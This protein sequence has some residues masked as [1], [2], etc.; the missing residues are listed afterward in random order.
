MKKIIAAILAL[1]AFS[2]IAQTYVK[3]Y[4][5]K[6]GTYVEGHM[7][8]SPN[9][10]RYDNYGAKDNIYGNQNPYTGQRGSQPS[11]LSSPPAYNQSNPNFNSFQQCGYSRSGQ[12]V[13][14]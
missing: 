5:R 1:C 4:V 9:A 14:R 11:E 13:C 2:A 6:D 12:Y 8:S 3:P 10:N 7:R